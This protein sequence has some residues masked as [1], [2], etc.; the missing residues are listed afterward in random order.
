MIRIEIFTIFLTMPMSVAIMQ[1]MGAPKKDICIIAI[2]IY[3]IMNSIRFFHGD[4]HLMEDLKG[5][6]KEDVA[7]SHNACS[8]FIAIASKFCFLLAAY[9][10]NKCIAFFAFNGLC[11]LFDI[12]WRIILQNTVSRDRPRGKHLLRLFKS[13]FFL[14]SFEAIISFTMA[15]VIY[16]N[17]SDP[18][19]MQYL[20]LGTIGVLV[21][22]ML[23]DYL[24]NT[25]HYFKQRKA[26]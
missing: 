9:H 4:V 10:L 25:A 19:L 20:E 12:F 26:Q 14:G 16:K 3:F 13:W 15:I 7:D 17:A 11:F 5:A 22:I 8:F 2:F 24:F 1:V 6:Q 21:L 18:E 23:I